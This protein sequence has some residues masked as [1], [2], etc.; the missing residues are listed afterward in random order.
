[1]VRVVVALAIAGLVGFGAYYTLTTYNA[2]E[3]V[4]V[5]DSTVTTPTTETGA[6]AAIKE[7][8]A[9]YAIDVQYRHFGVPQIDVQVDAKIHDMVDAFKKDAAEFPSDEPG[10]R[11]YS[12]GGETAAFYSG[13]IMSERLNMYQDMG[14]AH[15][16]PIVVGLNFDTKTGKEITLNQ[17]LD[18]IGLSLTQVSEK[19]LAELQQEFGDSV[20]TSGAEP[21]PENYA[22]F[23]VTPQ[24]VTFVFQ[25]Y[26]VVAYAAGMPEITFARKK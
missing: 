12:F 9:R 7:E 8:T 4:H 13:D 24:N 25:A 21:T 6:D 19:A 10:M 2:G 11:P 16:L 17:A 15:G 3:V 14:G 20:F 22:T 23:I 26:Q 5:P 1:M 18:M